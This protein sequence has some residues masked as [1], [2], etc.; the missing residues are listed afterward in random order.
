MATNWDMYD[1]YNSQE[2]NQEGKT[3]L[4]GH[5]HAI[6][7]LYIKLEGAFASIELQN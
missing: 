2:N 5:C 1:T 7:P 6:W 4:K 3:G